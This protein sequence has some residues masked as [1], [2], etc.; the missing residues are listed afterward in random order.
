L[1]SLTLTHVHNV[2]FDISNVFKSLQ[3]S[4]GRIERREDWGD[5]IE[6]HSKTLAQM[7]A[8]EL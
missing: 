5:G 1:A 6:P 7:G 2:R 8:K 4:K 3:E